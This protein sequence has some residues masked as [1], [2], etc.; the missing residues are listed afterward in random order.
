MNK[1]QAKKIRK[2]MIKNGYII[3]QSNELNGGRKT[4]LKFNVSINKEV[5]K[6]H[7]IYPQHLVKKCIDDYSLHIKKEI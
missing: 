6:N 3:C 1:R 2:T 5:I 7:R 4:Y